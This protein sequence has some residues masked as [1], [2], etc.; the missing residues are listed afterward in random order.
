MTRQRPRTTSGIGRDRQAILRLRRAGG[1]PGPG[2]K[3]SRRSGMPLGSSEY[4]DGAGVHQL[5][6]PRESSRLQMYVDVEFTSRGA[7]GT[8]VSD[9]AVQSIGDRQFLFL[10]IKDNPRKFPTR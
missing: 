1:C 2:P 5:A 7:V 3:Q 10:P 9:T 4:P 8:V 6:I